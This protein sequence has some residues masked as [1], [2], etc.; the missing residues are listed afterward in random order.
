MSMSSSSERLWKIVLQFFNM[1]DYQALICRNHYRFIICN[2]ITNHPL[3]II[4]TCLHLLVSPTPVLLVV[5]FQVYE[6]VWSYWPGVLHSINELLKWW[7]TRS[8]ASKSV[9]CSPYLSFVSWSLI[10]TY[11]HCYLCNNLRWTHTLLS[12]I[13]FCGNFLPK[14]SKSFDPFIYELVVHSDKL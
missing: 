4:Q 9:R 8:F 10:Y 3:F 2:S 13:K 5:R 1:D 6:L 11:L 7:A 14:L 12:A